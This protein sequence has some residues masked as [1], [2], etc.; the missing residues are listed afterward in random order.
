MN[1]AEAEA[2]LLRYLQIGRD[3]IVWKLEGLSEYD[4][5]R[6]MV[7]SGTNLLGIVKH[8]AGVEAGYLG[9]VFGRT[10]PEPLPWMTEEAE[11]NA[12]LWATADESRE[13]LLTLYHRVWSHADDTVAAVELDAVGEV[14][15]WPEDRRHP[16][17]HRVL[18]HVATEVHR[19]AGHADIVRELLDGA[20]GHRPGVD[21]LPTVDDDWWPEHRGR[22]E[23][24]ARRAA[25]IDDGASLR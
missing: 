4:V 11:P 23:S 12:D 21:N 17:L 16:T 13:D 5:R 24:V 10:F 9:A 19:H 1:D 8:L 3:A 7:R 18:I 22:L 6:P 15:W 20:I 14:P 25:G 2:D